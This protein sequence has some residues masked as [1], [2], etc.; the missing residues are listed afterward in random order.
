MG[1][2]FRAPKA[3]TSNIA[4]RIGFAYDPTGRGK[5]SEEQQNQRALL[6]RI[7]RGNVQHVQSSELSIG[8]PTNNGSID[9]A[10]TRIRLTWKPEY[11]FTYIRKK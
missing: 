7:S 10:N 11:D 5:W 3:D 4:P 2:F 1:L 8:L 9:Q 6:A